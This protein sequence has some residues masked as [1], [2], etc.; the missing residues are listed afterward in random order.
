MIVLFEDGKFLVETA[1]LTRKARN[2]AARDRASILVDGRAA[3]GRSVMVEAEGTA[4]IVGLPEADE[5]NHRIRAKYVVP[6]AVAVLDEAWSRFD[7]LSIEITPVRWRSWTGAALAATTEAS[8]GR[9]YGDI[10]KPD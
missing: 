3:T 6:D 5:I 9:P 8:L 7:D 10:W 4:R 1:S 2:V